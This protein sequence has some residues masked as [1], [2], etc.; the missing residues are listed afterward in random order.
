MIQVYDFRLKEFDSRSIPGSGE[1]MRV[2]TLLKLQKARTA[3]NA[4]IVI[5]HAFRAKVDAERI[6]RNNPGAVKN[7]AHEQGFGLDVRP[8]AELKTIGDWLRFL[9]AFWE[10]GFRRFGIMAN[11]LHVDDDPGRA[12][13]ALWKYPQT[14]ASIWEEVKK[15]YNEKVSG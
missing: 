8:A 5:A 6:Q 7:S 12:A 4:P 10:G 15:W 14:D 2:G 11:T 13:P 1:L 9:D 3:F